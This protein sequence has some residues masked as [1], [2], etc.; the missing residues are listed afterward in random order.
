MIFEHINIPCPH[1]LAQLESE[2]LAIEDSRRA[3]MRSVFCPD[4]Q[5]S[6]TGVVQSSRLIWWQMWP[7]ATANELRTQLAGVEAAV[8][9]AAAAQAA[10]TPRH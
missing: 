2:L 10:D 5:V 3:I 4:R 1:C 9:I 8:T 6:L 7:C